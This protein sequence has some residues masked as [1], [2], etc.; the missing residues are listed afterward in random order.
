MFVAKVAGL[1]LR[2]SVLFERVYSSL[3]IVGVCL[4]VIV[5]GWVGRRY[6]CRYWFFA[7]CLLVNVPPP[8]SCFSENCVYFHVFGTCKNH[9]FKL[10]N[11]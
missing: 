9:C 5:G 11:C 7:S 10:S 3:C 1:C 6:G 4:L 8:A 2:L